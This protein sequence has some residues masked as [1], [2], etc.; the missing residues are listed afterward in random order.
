MKPKSFILYN[1]RQEF[2]KKQIFS[3]WEMYNLETNVSYAVKES[4]GEK[5]SEKFSDWKC[6]NR[7]K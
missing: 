5:K 3:Y 7:R 6:K 2:S 1:S 4:L